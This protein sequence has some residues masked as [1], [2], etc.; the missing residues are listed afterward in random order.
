MDT[1]RENLPTKYLIDIKADILKINRLLEINK[2]KIIPIRDYINSSNDDRGHFST[3][4]D[5]TYLQFSL[6]KCIGPENKEESYYELLDWIKNSYIEELFSK[7]KSPIYRPRLCIIRPG[8]YLKPHIDNNTTK[9][10]RYMIPL[11]TNPWALFGQRR[12]NSNIVEINHFKANGD[13][14]FFNQGF[15]HSAWNFGNDDRIHLVFTVAGHHEIR[16]YFK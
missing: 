7:F 11:Q 4:N 14:W 9:V 6:A 3:Y 16:K 12:K 1:R 5:G 8:G 10:I 13:I 15:E 2:D